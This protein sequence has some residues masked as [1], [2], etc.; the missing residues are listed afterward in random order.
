MALAD[1]EK[2]PSAVYRKTA[3]LEFPFAVTKAIDFSL[4]RTYGVPSIAYIF[5]KNKQFK[6]HVGKR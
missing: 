6:L 5:H 1:V 2:D 3:M 4:F